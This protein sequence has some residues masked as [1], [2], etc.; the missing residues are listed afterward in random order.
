M[1][2]QASWAGSAPRERSRVLR[3]AADRLR[4]EIDS[5]AHILTAEMGKPLAES[6]CEVEFAADYLEWFGEE[7]V[8][9]A[10]RTSASPDGKSQHLVV[11]TP[12]DRAW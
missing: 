4:D 11:R 8:R 2:A 1:A 10:G 12:S 6:R 9:V 5:F 7:A 3:R